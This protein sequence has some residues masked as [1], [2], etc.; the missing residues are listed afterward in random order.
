MGSGRGLYPDLLTEPVHCP[1]HGLLTGSVQ[2]LQ[3]A[4]QEV[5]PKTGYDIDWNHSYDSKHSGLCTSGSFVLCGD[6]QYEGYH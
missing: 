1:F 2:C 3:I 5:T 4:N 6:Y